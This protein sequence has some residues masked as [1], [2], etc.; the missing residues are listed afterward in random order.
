[1]LKTKIH[2]K[3]TN[4][5]QYL[6]Y[7]SCHP[8][9]IK[10]SIP[11]SLSLRAKKLCSNQ[12]DFNNYITNLTQSL[13]ERGYPKKLIERQTKSRKNPPR[14]NNTNDPK[15]LTQYHP[16]LHKINKILKVSYPIL[17]NCAET[18]S[19]FSKVPKVIFKKPPNLKNILSKPKFSDNRN[20][21]TGSTRTACNPC[22][23]PRCGTCK[24]ISNTNSFKSHS[25]GRRYPIRGK[26]DCNTNN[27]IYQLTCKQCSKDYI[28]QTV[29]PLRVRMTNHRFDVAHQNRSRP[30]S[31]HAVDHKSGELENCYTLKGIYHLKPNPDKMINSHEL[32]NIEVAHQLVLRSRQPDGLNIR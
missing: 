28:G 8:I 27:V 9:H 10:K 19:L 30:I 20:Q 25:T 5:M 2:V 6:H 21:D 29:T 26:I 18:R 24:I 4:K 12:A 32:R 17:E 3:D 16:G 15:F 11:K 22:E 23:R 31:A 1:M 14:V 7:N 13:E